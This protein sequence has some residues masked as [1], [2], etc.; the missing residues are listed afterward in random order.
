MTWAQLWTLL[1]G[2]A[3]VVLGGLFFNSSLVNSVHR[4]ID[5]LRHG[6][7]ARFGDVDARFA[8]IDS[9]FAELRQDMNTRLA[10]LRQDVNA[11]F[12]ELRTDLHEIR[13]LLQEALRTRA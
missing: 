10:E 8:T 3:V 6:M 12:T 13:T 4:R 1:G 9:R 5:D 2:L 7:D 11:R